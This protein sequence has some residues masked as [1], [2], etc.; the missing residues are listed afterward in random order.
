MMRVHQQRRSTWIHLSA[1]CCSTPNCVH[2]AT[3]K[4]LCSNQ[5]QCVNALVDKLEYNEFCI[6]LVINILNNITILLC[7][8]QLVYCS[9]YVFYIIHMNT[10]Y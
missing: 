10:H 3:K 1:C 2:G 4:T 6:I 5:N 9:I 7:D 8:H